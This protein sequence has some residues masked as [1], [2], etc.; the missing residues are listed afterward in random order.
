MKNTRV[1]YHVLLRGSMKKTGTGSVRNASSTLEWFTT[2]QMP[3]FLTDT[4][5]T[6]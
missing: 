1:V 6:M 4:Y 3:I 2:F 5:Y